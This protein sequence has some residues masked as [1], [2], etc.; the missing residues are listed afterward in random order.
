VD[1]P[2]FAGKPLSH[3]ERHEVTSDHTMPKMNLAGM[4]LLFPL[5]V[6][7]SP[8]QP[9][10]LQP[11]KET[12]AHNLNA[13]ARFAGIW[14]HF[15]RRGDFEDIREL[16]ISTGGR[17][18]FVLTSRYRDTQPVR[19]DADESKIHDVIDAVLF[20]DEIYG[21]DRAN[22]PIRGQVELIDPSNVRYTGLVFSKQ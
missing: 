2:A 4:L 7:A 10:D 6:P 14:R 15:D 17:V 19:L 9:G 5:T 11:V 13:T 18:S 3:I 21:Y 22:R 20:I 8:G 12:A 1:E 16:T